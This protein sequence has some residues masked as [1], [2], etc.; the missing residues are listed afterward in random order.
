[1]CT[2]QRSQ[3]VAPSRKPQRLLRFF[4]FPVFLL[5]LTALGAFPV[6]VVAASID[7]PA[8]ASKSEAGKPAAHKAVVRGRKHGATKLVQKAAVKPE[9]VALPVMLPQPPRPNWPMNDSPMP[10]SITW[11]AAG[12]RIEANNASLKQ[13][14]KEVST[15]TGSSVEGMDTDERVYGVYGPGSAREVLAKLFYGSAY[16]LLL[17]GDSG[18]GTPRQIVLARRDGKPSGSAAAKS[19]TPDDDDDVDVEPEEQQQP[20][21]QP[22]QI[23]NSNMGGPPQGEQFTPQQQPNGPQ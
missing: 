4:L 18:Q 11:N 23:R 5:L 8:K 9:V 22:P 14:L 10:A 12:L 20:Q 2:A 7:E 17:I 21:G 1:M 16:N 19:A 3:P 13:I 6:A 15:L